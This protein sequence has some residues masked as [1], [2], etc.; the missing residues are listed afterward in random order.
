MIKL[1]SRL[2]GIKVLKVI[3]CR[4]CAWPAIRTL[5]CQ[6]TCGMQATVITCSTRQQTDPDCPDAQPCQQNTTSQIPT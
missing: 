1:R 4:H 3:N 2:R 6:N 5:T